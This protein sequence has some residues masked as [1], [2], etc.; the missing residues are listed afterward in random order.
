M[1]LHAIYARVLD[2]VDVF[3]WSFV[4]FSAFVQLVMR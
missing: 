3:F 2:L 4:A 1:N